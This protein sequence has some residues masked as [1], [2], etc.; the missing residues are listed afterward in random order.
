MTKW[1]KKWDG[2]RME[3]T[4]TCADGRFAELHAM[5]SAQD[6]WCTF[7]YITQDGDC[8]DNL[9]GYRAA[10][11]TAAQVGELVARFEKEFA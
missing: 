6:V 8:E 1:T 10:E 4:A 3:V 11:M 9:D 7:A 2:N 5:C